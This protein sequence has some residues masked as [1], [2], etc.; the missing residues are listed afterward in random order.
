M[1][2]LCAIY[3]RILI[4]VYAKRIVTT[5][6]VQKISEHHRR[7][8][9]HFHLGLSADQI[10][11]KEFIDG[12]LPNIG[13]LHV[14]EAFYW[15]IILLT[16]PFLMDY[17]SRHVRNVQGT[18]YGQD[19]PDHQSSDHV[20]VHAC[21]NSAICTVDLLKVLLVAKGNPKSLPFVVNSLFVAGLVLGLGYF[22]DIYKTYALESSLKTAL[23]LLALFPQDAIAKRYLAILRMLLDACNT[24]VRR[25]MNKYMAREAQLVNGMFGQID[26]AQTTRS[27]STESARR[28]VTDAGDHTQGEPSDYRTTETVFDGS[29]SAGPTADNLYHAGSDMS[30]LFSTASSAMPGFEN[31]FLVPPAISSRTLWFGSYEDN[32]PFFSTVNARSLSSTEEMQ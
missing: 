27:H 3:E 5:E 10:N 16:R 19:K 11:N 17:V 29:N 14:K 32:A 4:D 12:L 6:T 25:L 7:W 21:I 1:T 26:N 24:Y 28:I 22:G 8:T 13:L 18:G 23:E 31:E 30:T 15:T 2:D 9:K 20:L